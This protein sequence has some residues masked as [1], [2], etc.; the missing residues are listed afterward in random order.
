MKVTNL[1]FWVVDNKLSERFYKKLGFTLVRSDDSYSEVSLHDFRIGLVTV[2]DEAEFATD[3]F[4]GERGKGM[5]VYVKVENVD[6]KYAEVRELNIKVVAGPRTWS[7]GNREF[8]VKDP[9]GY[10]LCFWQP[11]E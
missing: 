8:V 2:R 5:Y 11:S 7:W 1:L 4:A 6:R 9:D 10:K 3:A